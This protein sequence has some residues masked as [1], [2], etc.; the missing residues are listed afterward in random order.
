MAVPTQAISAQVK[1]LQA[2]LQA[3]SAAATVM[4][5]VNVPPPPTLAVDP[6]GVPNP[7]V[8]PTDEIVEIEFADKVKRNIKASWQRQVPLLASSKIMRSSLKF[9]R[10]IFPLLNGDTLRWSEDVDTKRELGEMVEELRCY[11]MALSEGQLQSVSDGSGFT[12]Q[13]NKVRDYINSHEAA[14]FNRSYRNATSQFAVEWDKYVMVLAAKLQCDKMESLK[15]TLLRDT[16]VSKDIYSLLDLNLKYRNVVYEFFDWFDAFVIKGDREGLVRRTVDIALNIDTSALNGAADVMAIV[17]NVLTSFKGSSINKDTVLAKLVSIAKVSDLRGQGDTRRNQSC[18]RWWPEGQTVQV[19]SSRSGGSKAASG[20]RTHHDGGAYGRVV[21]ASKR[22]DT[23]ARL[24]YQAAWTP[25]QEVT[26]REVEQELIA[27]TM[28]LARAQKR[29][30]APPRYPPEVRQ[31][32]SAAY[33]RVYDSTKDKVAAMRA[34]QEISRAY[35]TAQRHGME[36]DAYRKYPSYDAKVIP[37][38][39]RYSELYSQPGKTD[40]EKRA[41]YKEYMERRKALGPNPRA[42]RPTTAQNYLRGTYSAY[43]TENPQKFAQNALDEEAMLAA[44]Y[45]EQCPG[46]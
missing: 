34:M 10:Y 30:E 45:G 33:H 15:F 6:A 32:M 46:W 44:Q 38:K 42:R 1:A 25:D 9:D 18:W 39:A 36:P 12:R 19:Q 21:A 27:R 16:V 3:R 35:W 4:E 26:R 40:I 17:S 37:L 13:I 31:Q 43:R 8:E 5:P 11:G 14:C 41:I 24:Y 28:A 23:A 29:A 20:N 22:F 2:D 7:P